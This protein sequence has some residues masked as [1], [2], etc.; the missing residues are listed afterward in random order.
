MKN[1]YYEKIFPYLIE[2]SLS[3]DQVTV[4]RK[5]TLYQA[6]GDILEIGFGTGL[7]LACY[8]AGIKKITVV[9][10]HPNMNRWAERRSK[11]SSITVK[12]HQLSAERMPFPD[13]SFDCVVS[14]W[15]LCSIPSVHVA[16]SEIFRVLKPKG[17]F[18]FLE[19]GLS[20]EANVVFWQ[21][22]L[23]PFYNCLGGGC[24]LDR[25]IEK[26]IAVS[27]LKMGSINKFYLN[28]TPRFNGYVY[29]GWAEKE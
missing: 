11:Q 1:I 25:D 3:S 8:P 7:N 22:R 13:G 23:N 2:K 6:H 15:T 16:L 28:G 12:Y 19:H 14:T 5:S 26:I 21:K 20:P 9:E 4:L 24:H 17:R 27:G 29:Q 18:L 10:E